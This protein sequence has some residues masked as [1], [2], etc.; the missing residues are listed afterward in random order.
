MREVATVNG[1]PVYSDK[2][3]SGING[4][5]LSFSDGSWCDVSTGQVHN[6][7]V[8]FISVG[9]VPEGNVAGVQTKS[10]GPESY[11]ASVLQVLGVEADVTVE[12]YDG[13]E[14]I[15]EMSGPQTEI[16][17]IH[18]REQGGTLVIDGS[19]SGRRGGGNFLGIQIGGRHGGG[20][21][22]S[23]D[24]GSGTVVHMSG[25]SVSI[26]SDGDSRSNTQ[27]TVKVPRRTP[28]NFSSVKGNVNVGDTDGAI[29]LS[30]QGGWKATIGRV[31][32]ANL[33]LQG[34]GDIDVAN[35]IGALT[36]AVQGSGSIRVHDG[37]ITNLNATL[38]GS[39]DIKVGGTAQ[40]AMLNMQGSGGIDVNHVVNH[41]AKQVMG[42]GR[43]RVR[44]VG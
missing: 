39:G 2:S 18:V 27:I 24:G 3:L 7:G 31:S 16:D 28:T 29:N 13:S 23:M 38:Q 9:R 4:T 17:N 41:P 25:A 8:G 20:F 35:V 34:S 43:I 36:I 32:D 12:P 11:R 19:S 15:V 42:S 22:M 33:N 26:G 14:I 6:N 30:L 37:G 21:S 44:R 40:N 1:V 10:W 5:R